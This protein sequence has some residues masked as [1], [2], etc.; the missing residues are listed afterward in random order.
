VNEVEVA[1]GLF[2]TLLYGW[3]FTVPDPRR[4]RL[5]VDQHAL[6]A[7]A[8]FVGMGVLAWGLHRW[9][10]DTFVPKSCDQVLG[11]ANCGP[12]RP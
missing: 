4:R 1:G 6:W 8:V 11:A 2:V 12:R 5:T 3:V 9:L 10:G 7:V